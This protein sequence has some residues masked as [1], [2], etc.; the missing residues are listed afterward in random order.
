MHSPAPDAIL[1]R[2]ILRSAQ[3]LLFQQKHQGEPQRVINGWPDSARPAD[4]TP[5]QEFPG[6]HLT[7]AS[8]NPDDQ[9]NDRP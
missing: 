1:F 5:D 6:P 4:R 3:S 9:E 2:T 7:I 8:R